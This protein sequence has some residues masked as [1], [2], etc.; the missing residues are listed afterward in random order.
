MV[1]SILKRK[2]I[3]EIYLKTKSYKKVRQ[4]FIKDKMAIIFNIYCNFFFNTIDLNDFVKKIK[5]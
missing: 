4:L 2:F 1:Y 3:L 5:R